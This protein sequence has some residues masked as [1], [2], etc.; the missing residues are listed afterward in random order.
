MPSTQTILAGLSHIARAFWPV[1]VGWHVVI[2]ILLV[3]L[4]RGRR[5]S[6]RL[7]AAILTAP[8]LSVSLLAFLTRSP[9]NGAVFAAVAGALLG[10]AF[11]LDA[12]P[13]RRAG[14]GATLVAAG[15][16][17]FAWLYPHFLSGASPLSY[18]VAAPL[19][20]IPCPTLSL[21]IGFGLL[22]QG[23]G[24]RAWVIV[25]TAAGL[26]YGLFGAFRLGVRIDVL[27]TFGAA[28]L[29]VLGRAPRRPQPSHR[30]H[31]PAIRRQ[32]EGA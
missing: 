8:L 17:A 27:L 26:F 24:S 23:F 14:T 21:V 18:L 28:S 6:R 3:A 11:R 25:M 5:P 20:L 22:F 12:A 30:R 16:I 2:S 7:A 9:F 31:P 15:M 4:L 10:I 29:A 13:V 1:A 32:L 19:G